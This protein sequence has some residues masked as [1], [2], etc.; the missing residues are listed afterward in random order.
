MG[1]L[2][3]LLLHRRA[4]YLRLLFPREQTLISILT[5]LI[6]Y[7]KRFASK[8]N[9]EFFRPA[10]LNTICC[11]FG[12]L[13]IRLAA[14][15]FPS[16]HCFDLSFN[17]MQCRQGTP[18]EGNRKDAKKLLRIALRLTRC[19]GH[20]FTSRRLALLRAHPCRCGFQRTAGVAIDSL[21]SIPETQFGQQGQDLPSGTYPF[22]RR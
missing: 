12:S 14:L 20:R 1:I 9:K 18:W 13:V 11:R 7:A 3:S 17:R 10:W 2:P 8:V 16:G 22:S 6:D 4:P 5:P 21:A 15:L 19:E